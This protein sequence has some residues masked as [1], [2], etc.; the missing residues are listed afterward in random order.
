MLKHLTVIVYKDLI[1]GRKSVE[2]NRFKN[3][4][5]SEYR[6]RNRNENLVCPSGFGF[7]SSFENKAQLVKKYRDIRALW[8]IDS[9]YGYGNVY[10]WYTN[11]KFRIV[12]WF[13][14]NEQMLEAKE[15]RKQ[16]TRPPLPSTR[17][18]PPRISRWKSI[19]L[20]RRIV[21]KFYTKYLSTR[22]PGIHGYFPDGSIGTPIRNVFRFYDARTIRSIL[23]NAII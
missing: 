21:L 10:R 19:F 11:Q 6:G 5:P 20:A 13:R 2:W 23:N 8:N 12:E 18:P 1:S 3:F 7:S 16:A 15:N 17:S 22:S 9:I 4:L 14:E